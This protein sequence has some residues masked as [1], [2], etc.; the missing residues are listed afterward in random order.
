MPNARLSLPREGG[1]QT[2]GSDQ[3]GV[4]QPEGLVVRE[5]VQKKSAD[6]TRERPPTQAKLFRRFAIFPKCQKFYAISQLF[7]QKY[8]TWHFGRFLWS[9]LGG[10]I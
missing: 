1:S 10:K 7:A 2:K 9:I 4:V 5:G 6:C 3:K 8:A